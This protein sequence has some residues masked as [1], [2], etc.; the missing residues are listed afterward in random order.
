MA[1]VGG[2]GMCEAMADQAIRMVWV[3]APVLVAY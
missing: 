2:G 3:A 1:E